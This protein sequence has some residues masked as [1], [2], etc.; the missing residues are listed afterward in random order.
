MYDIPEI[1]WEKQKKREKIGLVV[2]VICI[3]AIFAAVGAYLFVG[4]SFDQTASGIDSHVGQL[5]GYCTIVFDGTNTKRAT[6]DSQPTN[7]SIPQNCEPASLSNVAWD[8]KEKGSTVCNI[9]CS[10]YDAYEK[11]EIF[12]RGFWKIGV[13]SI[14]ED[15]LKKV[16][17]SK[18]NQIIEEKRSE[19][20]VNID[21]LEA[22]VKQETGKSFTSLA[23]RHKTPEMISLQN[24]IDSLYKEN[25]ADIV[26]I[27]APHQDVYNVVDSCDCIIANTVYDDIPDE[28]RSVN[29]VFITRVPEKGKVGAILST[30]AKS[31]SAKNFTYVDK[32]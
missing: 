24:K 6:K 23:V 28:G 1:N 10:D 25:N 7:E 2:F 15:S 30:P 17:D 4:H 18:R 20:N 22:D 13:I 9:K 11:G 12:Q 21:K 26:I 14:T 16:L 29:S 31:L 5:N 3:L 27:L 19:G 8:Y 32:H